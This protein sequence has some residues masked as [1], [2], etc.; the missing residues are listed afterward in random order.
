MPSTMFRP[1]A[2]DLQVDW[3]ISG[4]RSR[5]SSRLQGF[6][7]HEWM[8]RQGVPSSIVAVDFNRIRSVRDRRFVEI[9]TRLRRSD[10]THV[11]FEAPEWTMTM[12]ARMCSL[13][14]RRV[15]AVR[16][17]RIPEEYDT[18]YDLTIT[19]TEGLRQ[20]LA[21]RRG[22]VINDVVEV[23]AS[24]CKG[25]YDARGERLRV[26]WLGHPGYEEFI[27]GLIARLRAVPEISERFDFELI[28]SGPF[29]TRQW[30]EEHVV[31]DVLD[32]DI[33]LLALPEGAWYRNKSSNRLAM[34]FSLGMPVVATLIPSYA[35]LARHGV[36]GLFVQ[37]EDEIAACLLELADARRRESL[38]REA[39]RGLGNAF[40]V[41]AIGPRWVDAIASA[42]PVNLARR[43]LAPRTRA[44]AAWIGL[45][46]HL[47]TFPAAVQR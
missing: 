12:L 26:V 14:G 13:W 46:A 10:A 17:D 2:H 36:N 45:L 20:E 15:I 23:P 29:A 42:E 44:Y 6:L 3:I 40:R 43:R 1:L 35:E 7:I 24:A 4:D 25:S 16:S 27:V 21:I 5:A 18:Y 31:E 34:M 38:G 9:A 28:S 39:R 47:P 22:A 41:E 11:V 32:G 37:H 33:A 8:E 30:S 19:P